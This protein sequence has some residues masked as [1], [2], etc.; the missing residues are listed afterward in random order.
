M[1]IFIVNPIAGN[2][3]A[4]RVFSEIKQ[5]ELYHNINKMV[6]ITEY[7][8][9]AEVIASEVVKST[10]MI[11]ALIVISGDGTLHEVIN[12]TVAEGDVPIAF[13][14]GGSGND[15]ARGNHIK[16]KPLQIFRSII[17]DEDS[18][19]YWVGTFHFNGTKRYFV[20]SIGIGFDAE[21]A[22]HAN[23]SVMKKWLNSIRL[24]RLSYLFALIKVL[25]S[26]KFFDVKLEVD[27]KQHLYK[28][29]LLVLASNHQ[30][31]G[32]GLKIL[33]EATIQGKHL[34]ILIIHGI[35]KL[36]ILTLFS[37][38]LWGGH[39]KF[40]GVSVLQAKKVKVGHIKIDR[41]IYYQ[42][43]GETET[44]K[45]CTI[46]KKVKPVRILGIKHQE[47]F[48]DHQKQDAS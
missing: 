41:P 27:G 18:S 32:G 47:E 8:G 6:Y 13:I 30:F 26:F 36:K 24:G 23:E 25:F 22:K 42:V 44:F 35:S 19:P 15:F 39:I 5:T 48:V 29:C 3:K 14:P 4:K 34:S 16:K 31:V 33:P 1:Y 37:T 21:V 28:D 11:E 40:P 2:G 20:N 12:G 17:E 43:D 38:V 9:H 45:A 7:D 46:T 10:V